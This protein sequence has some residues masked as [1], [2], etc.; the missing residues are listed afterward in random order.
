MLYPD[1]VNVELIVGSVDCTSLKLARAEAVDAERDSCWRF[2]DAGAELVG[3]T[4]GT[5][6]APAV[7]GRSNG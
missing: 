3:V 1:W 6:G 4:V 5:P 2:W 7:G